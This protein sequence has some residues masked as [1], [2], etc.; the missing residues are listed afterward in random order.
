MCFIAFS[1]VKSVDCVSFNLLLHLKV[2]TLQDFHK[3]SDLIT[4]YFTA[5]NGMKVI[6][7]NYS[8]R[9]TEHTW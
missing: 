5:I 7:L 8:F 1:R 3:H 2:V 6:I 4:K 9:I